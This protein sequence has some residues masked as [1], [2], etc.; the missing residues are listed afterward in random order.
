MTSEYLNGFE[1]DQIRAVDI[2]FNTV[3]DYV[4]YSFTFPNANSTARIS[5]NYV[6]II[7]RNDDPEVKENQIACFRFI[8]YEEL[9]TVAPKVTQSSI[10]TDRFKRQEADCEV[11]FGGFKVYDSA[12]D[13]NLAIFQNGFI[14]SAPQFLRPLFI[15]PDRVSFDYND[16]QNTF[17]GGNEWRHFDLKSLQYVSDEL[18]GIDRLE[19]GW[20]AYLRTDIPEGKR[21]YS[22]QRDINGSYIIQNDLAD[23]SQLEAEYVSVHFSLAMNE[24][25]ESDVII[26]LPWNICNKSVVMKYSSYTQSYRASVKLKQGY[27]NY[28]YVVRDRY[29]G[30]N[31]LSLTEG[32]HSETENKYYYILYDSNPLYGYDRVIGYSEYNINRMP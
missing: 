2:S 29:V 24:I 30:E 11:I 1:G 4:H 23:D 28:R 14:H 18:S 7:Y 5:G 32:N 16:G 17:S 21:T 8:V 20:H 3:E 10:I 9:V 27:Y 13:L 6:A 12:R 22:S 19:D 25:S 26:E 31:D 15:R